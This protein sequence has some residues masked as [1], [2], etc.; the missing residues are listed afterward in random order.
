MC[1]R[2][3]TENEHLPENVMCATAI[4]TLETC[5]FQTIFQVEQRQNAFRVGRFVSVPEVVYASNHAFARQ[6]RLNQN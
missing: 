6:G 3:V 1:V 2:P 5:K 4:L